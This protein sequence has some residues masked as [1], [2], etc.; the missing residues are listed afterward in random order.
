MLKEQLRE[1]TQAKLGN[2]GRAAARTKAQASGLAP[3]LWAEARPLPLP[4][5]RNSACT[6]AP[7]RSS[8]KREAKER[9]NW[10]GRWTDWRGAWIS[11][12]KV[13]DKVWFW[14]ESFESYAYLQPEELVEENLHTVRCGTAGKVTRAPENMLVKVQFDG[15]RGAWDVPIFWV[16]KVR[17][18]RGPTLYGLDIGTTVYYQRGG[19]DG[20]QLHMLPGQNRSLET[21]TDRQYTLDYGAKGR[22]V[23]IP[24]QRDTD[25]TWR[26][27]VEFQDAC[28]RVLPRLFRLTPTDLV[29]SP[30]PSL[31][32]KYN[33]GNKLRYV[34][35][36]HGPWRPGVQ[37][38]IMEGCRHELEDLILGEELVTVAP[39][40]NGPDSKRVDAWWHKASVHEQIAASYVPARYFE[41]V[42]CDG[43]SVNTEQL[44]AYKQ[45]V[46]S[47]GIVQ[48]DR[49]YCGSD[50]RHPPGLY[51]SSDDAPDWSLDIG[52]EL[53]CWTHALGSESGGG[54]P[55]GGTCVLAKLPDVTGPSSGHSSKF[56]HHVDVTVIDKH[57]KLFVSSPRNFSTKPPPFDKSRFSVGST[58]YYMRGALELYKGDVLAFG[59]K[60]VVVDQTVDRN[61]S[62]H[63]HA[64]RCNVAWEDLAPDTGTCH[65]YD[66]DLSPTPFFPDLPRTFCAGDLVRFVEG[67][68]IPDD[69]QLEVTTDDFAI[70]FEGTHMAS[71]LSIVSVSPVVKLRVCAV[72][73]TAREVAIKGPAMDVCTH[74][75][76]MYRPGQWRFQVPCDAESYKANVL[77]SFPRGV[78]TLAQKVH[79]W[80][81][82]LASGAIDA[83][84]PAKTLHQAFFPLEDEPRSEPGPEAAAKV[85][86]RER[87]AMAV[88]IQGCRSGN[89]QHIH[90]A[91]KH[92]PPESLYSTFAQEGSAEAMH[93]PAHRTTALGIVTSY[94]HE[95]A[96]NALYDYAQTIPLKE[97]KSA[98]AH[99]LDT[100]CPRVVAD[101]LSYGCPVDIL[102]D[103]DGTGKKRTLLTMAVSACIRI[104]NRNGPDFLKT[105]LGSDAADAALRVVEILLK[106]GAD[107]NGS[108]DAQTDNRTSGLLYVAVKYQ[109]L[110]LA[111][112]LLLYGANPLAAAYDTHPCKLASYHAPSGRLFEMTAL[113]VAI[114]LGNL[115]MVKALLTR[116]EA[117]LLEFEKAATQGNSYIA[118][119]AGF[120]KCEILAYLIDKCRAAHIMDTLDT[121]DCV[122]RRAI[123]LLEERDG[124]NS[125]KLLL[126]AAAWSMQYVDGTPRVLHSG[127]HLSFAVQARK[128][129]LVKLLL[130]DGQPT[131][132]QVQEAL[133]LVETLLMENGDIGDDQVRD[134]HR[135][136]NMQSIRT[137]LVK[138][139]RAME[140]AALREQEESSQARQER[141]AAKK[142]QEAEHQAR[143]DAFHAEQTKRNQEESAAQKERRRVANEV[144]ERRREDEARVVAARERGAEHA[145]AMAAHRPRAAQQEPE[146]A[147]EGPPPE[148]V[149]ARREHHHAKKRAEQAAAE[150]RRKAEAEEREFNKPEAEQARRDL[151][152]ELRC[153]S[154]GSTLG[155]FFPT[156]PDAPP[157]PRLTEA[158]LFKHGEAG[159]SA[160]RD[161]DLVSLTSTPSTIAT[162]DWPVP[163][164]TRHCRQRA[165]QR[166][167]TEKDFKRVG[168][169]GTRTVQPDGSEKR[170]Y[171]GVTVVVAPEKEIAVTTYTNE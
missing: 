105:A 94:K 90:A 74:K 169:Y 157:T 153:K 34:G 119:A 141:E 120:E 82:R 127:G 112:I 51:Q 134:C 88:L 140:R 53:F 44:P 9:V 168:K 171:N 50:L 39:D 164:K 96:K 27:T 117:S 3:G 101:I 10:H 146:Q 104:V 130:R 116:S 33:I 29:R 165:E 37:G 102:L 5:R 162:K 65:V 129:D 103:V 160:P 136:A 20:L 91:M 57:G 59:A 16:S 87:G 156:L 158:A 15:T 49:F 43:M 124:V 118:F 22:V 38:L 163:H 69:S 23:E 17:P 123:T 106:K 12:L 93:G 31:K 80:D 62:G 77:T 35:P 84:S 154:K 132:H 126:A 67:F 14:P 152:Y 7:K 97:T 159:L 133:L 92:L 70:V 115:P 95:E 138:K 137:D 111:H 54:L 100:A 21:T 83:D 145:R 13:G 11:T 99:A 78:Y 25:D 85:A 113:H 81:T 63:P 110:P 68:V 71:P 61:T 28:E 122:L 48:P 170:E 108:Y 144:A 73:W 1:L 55:Y 128:A 139:Q 76:T 151:A 125:F 109:L 150:K 131:R 19:I 155:D 72:D 32:Y 161:D 52:A 114:V 8:G 45:P 64:L 143:L 148:V 30:L 36:P 60:G 75:I 41:R 46:D 89:V 142:K 24:E 42:A 18:N 66:A 135:K 149:A 4:P 2:L 58:V 98:L 166:G 56:K 147:A 86:A 26:I 79:L 47:S 167:V 40:T 6:M 121:W 107:P